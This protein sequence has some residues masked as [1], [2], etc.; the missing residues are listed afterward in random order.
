MSSPGIT[1]RPLREM[2][3]SALFNEVFLDEVFV[4]DEN[5][6]GAVNDGW[7]VARTTLAGERVALSQKMEA[8]ASDKDLLEFAR[9]RGLGP[10]GRYGWASWSRRAKRST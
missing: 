2:T 3:G 7:H 4:P 6:V 9:G 5:V 10:V 8:Y 1:V